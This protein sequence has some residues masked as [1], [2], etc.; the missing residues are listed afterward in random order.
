MPGKLPLVTEPPARAPTPPA[1]SGPGRFRRVIGGLGAVFGLTFVFAGALI[2]SV[3]VHL[4]LGP[5]RRTA[6]TVANAILGGMFKGSIVVGEIDHLSLRGIR[7][8]EARALDP[9]G[10]EVAKLQGL[11]ADTDVITIARSALF[12]GGQLRVPVPLV[13]VDRADITLAAGSG[14]APSIAD[15]FLL[16]KP[17]PPPPPNAVAPLVTLDRVEI[18]ALH[19]QGPVAAGVNLDTD[20]SRVTGSVRVDRDGVRVDIGPSRLDAR[21]PVPQPLAGD[22]GFHLRVPPSK[23]AEP[24]GPPRLEASFDGRLGE[25][26][27]RLGASMEGPHVAAKVEVPRATPAAISAFLPDKSTKLP[28]TRPAS[29]TVLA[30]G[31]LP[32]L[33]LDAK[34]DFEGGGGVDAKGKLSIAAPTTLD[35]AFVIRA[36]DPRVALPVAE[37]TPL[38]AKGRVKIGLGADVTIDA[39]VTTKPLSLAGQPIPAVEA[40]AALA[41]GAWR[42]SAKVDEPGAPT[43]ATFSFNPAEGLAFD[44]EAHASS[45]RGI[46][47]LQ[48]PV[49]GSARV[50]VTGTLKGDAL[51]AKVS[52][53]VDGIRAPGEVA[54]EDGAVEARVRGPVTAPTIEATVTGS[55]LRA[56][57]YAYDRVQAHASGPIAKLS[58]DARL[59]AGA[60]ESVAASG[61][62]DTSSKAIHG[63]KVEIHRKG[64]AIAGTV[65]RVT[66]TPAGVQVEGIALAGEGVGKLAGGLAVRGGEI[67]GKL[68]G[69]DVDLA[70]V[71]R[72]VGLTKPIAG[73]ANVDVDLTSP[74]PGLR[75]G[76]VALE[77][78]NGAA[79]GLNGLAGQVAASFDGDRLRVDGLLRVIAHASP[80]EPRDDRCDGAIASLRLTRGEGR[81]GGPLLDPATWARASGKVDVAADDWNLRCVA[82]LVPMIDYVASEVRGKLTARVGVERRPGARFPSMRHLLARTR[83]LEIAGPIDAATDRPEWESRSVDVEIKGSFD[84]ASGVMGA[85]FALDDGSPIISLGGRA[86]LDPDTLIDHPERRWDIIRRTPVLLKLTIPRR[87]VGAFGTLPTF[88]R[89]YLPPLGG[90]V[91]LDASVEGTLEKPRVEVHAKARGLAHAITADADPAPGKGQPPKQAPRESPWGI[92]VDLDV[93]LGYDGEKATASAHVVHDGATIADAGADFTVPLADVLAGRRVIPKGSFEAKLTRVPLGEIPFF[94]DRGMAGHLDG[95]VALEG[96]GTDPTLKAALSLPDLRIG[97]DLAYDESAI[98]VEIVRP[99]GRTAAAGRGTASARI[100]LS[101]KKGGRFTASAFSEI[102]WQNGLVPAIDPT[103][104][105]DLVAHASHFRIAAL[106]P[107]VAGVLSRVDGT[108]D[109]EARLGWTRLDDTDKARIAV[110]LKLADGIFHIPQLGQELH[111]AQIEI[112][113]GG[114]GVVVL[115]K[116]S[117]EGQKGR[118]T[119]SGKV[120]FDGL[121]F[122][123]A[124]AS[125]AIKPNEAMP[126]TLEGVPVGDA[127]GQVVLHAEKKSRDLA[128]TVGIP[129]F[130]VDLPPTTGR[131][132][133]ALDDNPDIVIRQDTAPPPEP[134]P[135]NPPRLALTFNLGEITV[136]HNLMEIAL[137]SVKGAPLRVVVADK[138][139]VSGD[140]QLTRGRVEVFKKQF[141]IEQGLIHLR[142]EDSANPYVNVTARW[143]SPD[144]DPIYIEYAGVLLPIE[145]KKLK[146]HSPKIPDD[147]IM[148]TLLFGSVEQSTV[149]AG[150]E[151]GVAPGQ[152]LAAQLIAQQFSTQIAGNISTSIGTNDDG[153]FRPGLVYNSGDKVIELSTYEAGGSQGGTTAGAAQPKGQRTQVTVDWR[154]WHNWLLRGRVDAGSDQTRMGV[155]VLWQYRY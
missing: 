122:L 124:D 30:E 133:Q 45:L 87:A 44:A 105:A 9:S 111:N 53:R 56:G 42:G 19:A 39:S 62:L 118:I 61:A 24:G 64:S 22:L 114:G 96:L 101:S 28:L 144:G 146:Y 130:H 89:K 142:P 123:G 103:R 97:N 106:S 117:A 5:T 40:E 13:H 84:P 80:K 151:K 34:V 113:G 92:P 15:T 74:G 121:R 129:R 99:K 2:V 54:L 63:V 134:R 152:G 21:A 46:S 31:D 139:E 127:Y 143:D 20:L 68:R 147:K 47:R 88:V 141:Q 110:R 41:K 58:L 78:V 116:L 18:D 59:D 37:A 132:V 93:A 29:A 145:A 95:S 57:R 35:L 82:R 52:G 65:D 98:S 32:E 71:A 109:A 83:G 14:G 137:S 104:P 148:A 60:G 128:V 86:T 75:R 91:Q 50:K 7:V 8:R 6:R 12:G 23:G 154:F 66:P 155:D 48:L 100:A 36:L 3:A 26:D 43:T 102:I 90:E 153:S 149:G 4:D 51:D 119:G 140:I 33:G 1:P 76:H 25:I 150:A 108:L 135:K 70:S 131:S 73:L 55:G 16:R 126:I 11:R 138:T 94:A 79:E 72:M 112:N 67:V 81:L 120:R 17:S 27:L 69:S 77:L 136:K 107:F 125:F 10:V 49:D 38:D 85:R 115:D